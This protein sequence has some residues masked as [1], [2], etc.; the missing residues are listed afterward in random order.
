MPVEQH[1]GRPRAEAVSTGA[2]KAARGVGRAPHLV[3][4][5]VSPSQRLPF[6]QKPG[7]SFC[8]S[9]QHPR[10]MH[11]GRSVPRGPELH[12]KSRPHASDELHARPWRSSTH[13]RVHGEHTIDA[14]HARWYFRGSQE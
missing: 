13:A 12:V 3:G 1:V 10:R 7:I 5:H 6:V 4:T 2:E 14:P 9:S 11:W 8:V